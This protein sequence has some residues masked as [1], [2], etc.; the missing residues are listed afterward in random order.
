M[1]ALVAADDVRDAHSLLG[2]TGDLGGE[3][4]GELGLEEA[5]EARDDRGGNLRLSSRKSVELWRR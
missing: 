5:I 1:L 4:N 3:R 2:R